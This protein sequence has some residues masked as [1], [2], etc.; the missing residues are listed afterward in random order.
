MK[1]YELQRVEGAVEHPEGDWIRYKDY[2]ELE[3]IIKDNDPTWD[4]RQVTQREKESLNAGSFNPFQ[5]G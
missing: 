1:R 2:E 3:A 5:D 4:G